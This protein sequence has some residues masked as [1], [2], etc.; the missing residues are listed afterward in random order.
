LEAEIARFVAWYN[1]ERYHE[2]L[3]NVT[4]D[5]VYYGRRECILNR[6]QELKEK[7]LA[8]RRRQNKGKPGPKE[9]GRTETPSLPQE[10]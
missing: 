9:P 6:R 7:T 5:H 2:G 4:P 10:A 1:T 8:R 3:G